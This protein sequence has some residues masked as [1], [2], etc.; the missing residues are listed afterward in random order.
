MSQSE[1]RLKS[2]IREKPERI[3]QHIAIIM[4][5]NGRWAAKRHLPRT[6]G[7]QAGVKAVKKVVTAATEIGVKY[8]TLFTFSSENWK[9]PKAEVEALMAL[10]SK[11]T[12]RELD[13][14]IRNDVRLIT[15]GRI[16]GLPRERREVLADAVEK[17]RDNRG[18]VLN[19]AL[20]Y[21]GR[22]EILDA[23]KAIATSILGG[24]INLQDVD[25][26]LFSSF[27][28]TAD[29]PDPDLLIRTSGEMRIS[30][31]LLWQTSYTEMHVIDTLWPDFGGRELYSAIID[32]QHR[33]RR[34]GK[35]S[36]ERDP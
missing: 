7:H 13:D 8:L 36:P 19:L 3:P 26:E 29:L 18:L 34:F 23:V 4:D 10:L 2:E 5:G 1:D 14:L 16:I 20:N 24:L 27:L 35:I 25:E 31:F 6:L 21:G 12:R 30:N 32:Y 17:T 15:T 11:T 33:E 9:R 28:Y 22:T